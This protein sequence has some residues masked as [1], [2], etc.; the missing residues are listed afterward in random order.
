MKKIFVGF[1]S[2]LAVVQLQS[3]TWVADSV[4]IGNGYAN[5]AFYSLENG[6]IG[7]IPNNNWDF[8]VAVYGNQTA[9]IRINGAFGVQL[10][11]YTNGDTTAWASLD[12]TGIGTSTGWVACFDTDT[13]YEPSAFEYNM[14]GHPNYGWGVYNSITHDVNGIALF[15]AKSYTGTYKKVWIKNQKAST[16]TMTIRVANLDGSNDTTITFTKSYTNKNYI[17]LALTN[18]VVN[19]IEPDNTTYDLIFDRYNAAVAPGIY[20]PVTGVRL[21]RNVQASEA[22]FIL[23]D[24][25]IY[26]NY[27]F[28]DNVTV[29]G[30]DWKIQPP[31]SWTMV[32]SLSYFVKDNVGN[33][34]QIAFTGFSGSSTGIYYFKKRQV[35]FASIE[36]EANN[37]LKVSVYPNPASELVQILYSNETA[38][39]GSLQIFDISGKAVYRTM[40]PPTYGNLQTVKCNPKLLGWQPGVYVALITVNEKN[41]VQKIIIQ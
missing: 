17:Y 2:V 35:A 32:D 18:L 23:P 30:H 36:D 11:Q 15:V 28:T 41:V 40:L 16:N 20:Y 1:V 4:V 13:A 3:Q 33:V 14:T 27:T 26:T 39:N 25:A 29:I 8:A 12:T 7:T 34:W 38:V 5:K 31:P 24:D 10:W 6:T 22:R 37:T 9:S 21:N 19:D